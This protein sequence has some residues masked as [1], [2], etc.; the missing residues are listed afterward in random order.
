[1]KSWRQ[2]PESIPLVRDLFDGEWFQ[3]F[4][5]IDIIDIGVK[6]PESYLTLA[7]SVCS[8]DEL[9]NILACS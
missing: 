9:R 2:G 5:I 1:M 8:A 6:A 4:D 7:N 3:W